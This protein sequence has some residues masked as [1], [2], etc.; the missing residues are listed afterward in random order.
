MTLLEAVNTILPYLGEHTI[1]RVEGNKHP[2]VQ[3]IVAAIDRKRKELLGE[4]LW[5]NEAVRTL[6][7]NTD[8]T[9]DVPT[10][11]LAVY[12]QDYDVEIDGERLFNLEQDTRYFTKPVKVK[13]IKDIPY[14]RLPLYAQHYVAYQAGAEIYV[15]DF[16]VDN[17]SQ[18]LSFKAENN[19]IK[20]SQE[21]L[22]KRKWNSSDAL[23]RRSRAF[24]FMRR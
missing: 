14:D 8:G 5:F 1:T 20:L 11:T 15:S 22:R 24:R 16:G 17:T 7:V 12:G 9:I 18:D 13:L 6:E 4:G 19:R 21:N 3:L 23:Y 10:G 2:T